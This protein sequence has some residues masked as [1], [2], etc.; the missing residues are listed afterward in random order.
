[1]TC[2][3][4]CKDN[5]FANCDGGID[6]GVDSGVDSGRPPTRPDAG[7]DGGQQSMPDAGCGPGMECKP[8]AIRY[9]DDPA[10]EW[11]KSTCD[12]NGMWGPCVAATVPAGAEG[13]GDCSPTD[14]SP[15]MCCGQ[16]SLCCQND[17]NGLFEDFGSG[18]CAA[19]SC[20]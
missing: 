9:C 17:P 7:K 16:L 12:A 6:S 14:Y 11:T 2:T 20:P 3:T 8:G 15:E 5:E 1:M 18:A 13:L 19:V 10:S 4:T